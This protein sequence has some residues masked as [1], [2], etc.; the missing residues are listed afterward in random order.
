MMTMVRQAVEGEGTRAVPLRD[1]LGYDGGSW[2]QP[3]EHHATLARICAD[4][5]D[6]IPSKCETR[7]REWLLCYRTK[8]RHIRGF[9]NFYPP[10]SLVYR[11]ATRTY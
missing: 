4:V 2:L 10:N 7:Q 5:F 6:R 9:M 8:I 1:R 11:R 3:T